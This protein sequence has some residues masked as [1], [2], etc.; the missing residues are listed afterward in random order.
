M[1]SNARFFAPLQKIEK[2]DNGTLRVWGVASTESVDEVGEVVTTAAMKAALPGFFKHGTGALREMHQ[3]IA[4]GTVDDAHIDDEGD[5]LIIATVVDK[6]AIDKV[7]LGVYKGFSIGGRVKERDPLKRHVI[8]KLDLGEISLVDRPCNPDAVL[9]IWKTDLGIEMVDSEEDA[10]DDI[11]ALPGMAQA[12]IKASLDHFSKLGITREQRVADAAA[13]AA[14]S[15][16]SFPIHTKEDLQSA[17]RLAGSTKDP[18]AAQQHFAKRAADIGLPSLV[19]H[20]WKSNMTV[21]TVTETAVAAKVDDPAAIESV[22]VLDKAAVVVVETPVVE[23]P[24]VVEPTAADAALAALEV[25]AKALEVKETKVIVA[26]TAVAAL[27]K[28]VALLTEDAAKEGAGA[29]AKALEFAVKV[30]EALAKAAVVVVEPV[31]DE[32][33]AKALAD[34][35]ARDEVLVKVTTGI[36]AL[37]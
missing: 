18:D 12:I 33:L 1:K 14:M 22:E 8:T 7:L 31:A 34:V 36:E 5:T 28:V 20:I 16:G 2:N 37:T 17:I 6:A 15:D 13:G 30:D 32:A 21:K 29:I 24:V 4:A 10:L 9:D 26:D 25:A 23:T 11:T 27:E 35:A 3:P 19:P